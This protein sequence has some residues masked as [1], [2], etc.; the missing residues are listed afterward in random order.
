LDK[1][2]KLEKIEAAYESGVLK[3]Q[4]S[5]HIV[6]YRSLDE[7]ERIILKLRAS[8]GLETTSFKSI[9]IISGKGL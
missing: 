5:D 3:V 1:Q 7:M 9:K 2:K 4:Y 8:L 6:I